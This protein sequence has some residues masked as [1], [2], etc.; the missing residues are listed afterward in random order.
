[1]CKTNNR[2]SYIRTR[3]K[4]GIH[5]NVKDGPYRKEYRTTYDDFD[6]DKIADELN[7]REDKINQLTEEN[8]KLKQKVNFY[9]YF[10]KKYEYLEEAIDTYKKAYELRFS[11]ATSVYER[12]EARIALDTIHDIWEQL[13]LIYLREGEID[14]DKT[15]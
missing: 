7:I 5:D 10:Q 14:E 12:R 1:M 6:L 9:K 3:Y 15:L 4:H 8:E 2:F 13:G 11:G